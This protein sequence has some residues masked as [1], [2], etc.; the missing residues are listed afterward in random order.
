V[1][2]LDIAVIERGTDV[3]GLPRAIVLDEQQRAGLRITPTSAL[4][5]H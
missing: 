3:H 5:P 1:P 2:E 4:L